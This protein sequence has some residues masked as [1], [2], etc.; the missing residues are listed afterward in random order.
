MTDVA[1]SAEDCELVSAIVAMAQAL[2]FTVLAEGVETE[3]QL[4]ALLDLDVTQAQGYLFSAPV[5]A[6]GAVAF[7]AAS[8]EGRPAAR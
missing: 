8:R 7:L 4:Q 5:P 2:G 6:A 3:E 1:R